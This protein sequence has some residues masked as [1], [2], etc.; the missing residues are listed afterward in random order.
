MPLRLCN[1]HR[2]AADVLIVDEALAV[3]D[4]F[5]Q[6]RC[7]DRISDFRERGTTLL[8]VSHSAPA[9]FALCDRAVLLQD[10]AV[11]ID[12]SPR[13]VIDLYNAQVVAKS[14]GA[15]M[16]VVNQQESTAPD[17]PEVTLNAEV[18]ARD[19]DQV[20][21]EPTTTGSYLAGAVR[22]ASVAVLQHQKPAAAVMADVPM[23]FRVSAEFQEAVSDPHVGFQVRDARGEVLYRAHTHG[24]GAVLG[25]A[26]AG[27][28]IEVDFS[29]A[30]DLMP[31]DYTLT[32]GI[33]AGGKAAGALAHSLLRHQDVV[34]FSVIRST[35]DAFWDGVVNLRPQ[36]MYRRLRKQIG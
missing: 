24:L 7:Y 2:D 30:P 8:F 14:S 34:S 26:S 29:F 12:G 3:G 35:E 21:A 4:I 17:A 10:G 13:E 27:D 15:S 20:A 5:F 16:R 11:A 22:L 36:V 23:T 9:V 1:C 32:V 25:D 6:Q 28:V 33:G 19:A 18:C 31:G